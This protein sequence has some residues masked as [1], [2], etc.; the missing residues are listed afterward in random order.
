MPFKHLQGF[1]DSL[2]SRGHLG[3]KRGGIEG[4]VRGRDLSQECLS[5][6]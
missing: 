6:G 4:G 3:S 1:I 2:P 5:L